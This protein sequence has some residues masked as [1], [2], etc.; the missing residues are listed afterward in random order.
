MFPLPATVVP[1]ALWRVETEATEK[2]AG[3]NCEFKIQGFSRPVPGKITIGYNGK[4]PN[5]GLR[6][7]APWF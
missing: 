2:L 6:T 4:Y 1:V 5:M 3:V 7:W